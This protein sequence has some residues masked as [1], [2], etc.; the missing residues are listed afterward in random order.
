MLPDNERIEKLE[1]EVML[2]SSNEL[3]SFRKWFFEF[4]MPNWEQQIA[5]DAQLG[6][7]DQLA[8][9]AIRDH[10]SGKTIEL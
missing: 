10:Q 5:Q 9:E 6:K 8:S 1:K 3:I 4:D 2:L 7:F